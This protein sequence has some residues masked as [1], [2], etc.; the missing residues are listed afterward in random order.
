[1]EICLHQDALLDLAAEAAVWLAHMQA[2]ATKLMAASPPKDGGGSNLEDNR[3]TLDSP[4][5]KK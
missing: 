2:R 1:V 4:M 5:G 3:S